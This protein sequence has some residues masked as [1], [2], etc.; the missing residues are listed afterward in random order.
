M[1]HPSRFFH[2]LGDGDPSGN[3]S[4]GDLLSATSC[5][6]T[7][8]TGNGRQLLPTPGASWVW[9]L[10]VGHPHEWHPLTRPT[11]HYRQYYLYGKGGSRAAGGF[12][13]SRPNRRTYGICVRYFYLPT[14]VEFRLDLACFRVC[15]R[16]AQLSISLQHGLV[17]V[18]VSIGSLCSQHDGAGS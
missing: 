7:P 1:G 17:G 11:T 18:H 5:A 2:S 3:C 13:Y 8:A 12:I 4:V 14:H 9:W 16:S 10:R 6:Q 15:D